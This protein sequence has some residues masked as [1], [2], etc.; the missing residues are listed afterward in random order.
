VG[1]WWVVDPMA[2]S[3]NSMSQYGY[4]GNNPLMFIDPNG[5][6]LYLASNMSEGQLAQ[7][8]NDIL[9][10]VNNAKFAGTARLSFAKTEMGI[11]VHTVF[12]DVSKED[13][14]NDPGL[15]L[16]QDVTTS[17]SKYLYEV[18]TSVTTINRDSEGESTFIL[19]TKTTKG[20]LAVNISTTPR[21]DVPNSKSLAAHQTLNGKPMNGFDAHIV[22][23]PD[24]SDGKRSD[25]SNIPRAW[26]TFHELQ[27]AAYRTDGLQ[28][29]E[30]AHRNSTNAGKKFYL[31][32]NSGQAV[33]NPY[34]NKETRPEK[35]RQ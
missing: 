6:E 2:E 27:E 14:A 7:A 20:S 16:L 28:S 24:A 22:V 18:G 13:I 33:D 1:R 9:N 10:L 34:K 17:S 5:M 32:G 4:V 15:S 12:Q 26:F 25:G 19:G 23:S 11:Q 29:Y 31:T 8:F 30:L 35:R 3:Y 21:L